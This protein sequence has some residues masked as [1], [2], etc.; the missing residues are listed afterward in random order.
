MLPTQSKICAS[1]KKRSIKGP[2]DEQRLVRLHDG[3]LKSYPT[4]RQGGGTAV[5]MALRKSL[6]AGDL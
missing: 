6:A 3:I 1:D 5:R 4:A 2:E